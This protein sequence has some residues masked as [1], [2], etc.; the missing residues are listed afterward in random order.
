[1]LQSKREA[2]AMKSSERVLLSPLSLLVWGDAPAADGG[3]LGA[4]TGAS[5][6]FS[7]TKTE[8]K[9]S[10]AAAQFLAL[11]LG[12]NWA[13]TLALGIISAKLCLDLK[14]TCAV[15][16]AVRSQEENSFSSRVGPR[17][18]DEEQASLKHTSNNA[19]LTHLFIGSICKW[20]Y[21]CFS[22][23]ML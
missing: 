21:G 5:G 9:S 11:V 17:G 6:G 3:S 12:W 14:L 2:A 4:G 20:N 16:S 19:H 15:L 8:L 13:E 22:R 10:V 23:F 7:V 1:M 18:V